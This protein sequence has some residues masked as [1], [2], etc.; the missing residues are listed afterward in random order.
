MRF[1]YLE[2]FFTIFVTFF[3]MSYRLMSDFYIKFFVQIIKW[4]IT[5]DI[6]YVEK[7]FLLL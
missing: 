2:Y 5:I 1:M 4:L 3:F 6:K 7:S